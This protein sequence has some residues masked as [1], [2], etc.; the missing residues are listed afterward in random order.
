M[1]KNTF[2]RNFDVLLTRR[3]M[4]RKNQKHIVCYYGN[5]LVWVDDKFSQP[6]KVYLGDDA[7]YNFIKKYD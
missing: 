7:L 5:K 2:K 4:G 1:S 6:F 3:I